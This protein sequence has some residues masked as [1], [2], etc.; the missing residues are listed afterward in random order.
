LERLKIHLIT[1]IALLYMTT[2]NMCMPVQAAELELEPCESSVSNPYG[3]KISYT[4]TSE[5]ETFQSYDIS[6][7]GQIAIVFSNST[8]GVFDHD[9][10]FQYQLSFD[11][12]GSA[13]V[14]WLDEKLLFINLRSNKAVE[15]DRNGSP[16]KYYDIAGPENYYN[17][18]VTKR[19]RIRG[20][21]KYFCTNNSGGDNPSVHYG[22]YTV[23][24]RMPSDGEE[25]I[26]YRVDTMFDG[27][28]GIRLVVSGYLSIYVISA[29]GVVVWKLKGR[30]GKNSALT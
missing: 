25:E 13:G 3:F 9:M 23:L 12:S 30:F 22:F 2:G 8:V 5:G 15:C 10:N 14:V 6:E 24:K 16:E 19:L 29:L 17:E 20:D 28:F 18:N 27:V 1:C 11:T 21:Y 4:W 7:G 26:L